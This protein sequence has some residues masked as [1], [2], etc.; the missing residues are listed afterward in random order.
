MHISQTVQCTVRIRQADTSFLCLYQELAILNLAK[1]NVTTLLT[2]N[3]SHLFPL[4]LLPLEKGSI[5]QTCLTRI[6]TGILRKVSF[7][8]CQLPKFFQIRDT[9]Q[10]PCGRLSFLKEPKTTKGLPQTAVCNLNI[11]LPA[12]KKVSFNTRLFSLSFPGLEEGGLWYAIK[13]CFVT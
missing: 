4:L 6:Q 1:F 3:C 12:H 13:E 2:Y 5:K 11:T 7:C 8:N 10:E 9:S